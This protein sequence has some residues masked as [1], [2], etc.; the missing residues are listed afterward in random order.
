[1]QCFKAQNSFSLSL[2]LS[3]TLNKLIYK[4]QT[5]FWKKSFLKSP[6]QQ[7]TLTYKLLTLH[8]SFHI[9]PFFRPSLGQGNWCWWAAFTRML[10]VRAFNE[11]PADST[12][13]NITVRIEQ[14][15][16]YL[17]LHNLWPIKYDVVCQLH[18]CLLA[19]CVCN[20]NK[21][22]ITN[23]TTNI[24]LCLELKTNLKKFLI[25]GISFQ[26]LSEMTPYWK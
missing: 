19:L 1:M 14:I 24:V 2:Y 7:P 26:K 20:D 15:I 12:F 11:H 6:I 13:C 18:T 25:A 10:S 17:R 16:M 4:I 9:S 23:I 8:Y 21:R 5:R 22:I 3:L